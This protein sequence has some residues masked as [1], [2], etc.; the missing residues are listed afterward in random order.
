MSMIPY[1][2]IMTVFKRTDKGVIMP[3]QCS[4]PV[5]D[6]LWGN[7]WLATEKIDGTNVRVGYTPSMGVQFGGRTDKAQ[8]PVTLLNKLA[9]LFP[10]EKFPDVFPDADND[11]GVTLYGEGYGAGIQKGG[12]YIPNGVDF[13]L[14]DVRVGRWW[15]KFDDV[16]DVAEKLGIKAVPKVGYFSLEAAVDYMAENVLYSRVAE[17]MDKPAEGIVLRPAVEDLQKR[18]GQRIIAKLKHVDFE[19]YRQSLEG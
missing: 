13:I 17:A 10:V 5:F 19:R 6:Y 16:E 14:F 11:I 18:S 15:L 2:K 12:W 7:D 3:D 4:D 1:P 9:D 8:M